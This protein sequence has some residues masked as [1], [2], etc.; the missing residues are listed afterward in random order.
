MDLKTA[1]ARTAF[2]IITAHRGTTRIGF[3]GGGGL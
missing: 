2:I 3:S 1:A